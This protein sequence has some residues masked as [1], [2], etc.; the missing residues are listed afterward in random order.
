MSGRRGGLGH[1][2]QVE[3]LLPDDEHR[4]YT[5]LHEAVVAHARAKLDESGSRLSYR[6]FLGVLLRMGAEAMVT[7]T[8]PA[9]N[10]QADR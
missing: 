6:E 10:G 8:T 5:G 2:R 1:Y 9:G 4:A 7:T 3:L